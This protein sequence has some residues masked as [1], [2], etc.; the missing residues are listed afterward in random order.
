MKRNTLV[1]MLMNI[2]MDI[3]LIASFL[4]ILAASSPKV[5]E[6]LFALGAKSW[7]ICLALGAGGA[8]NQYMGI[9][10][11]LWVVSFPVLLIV[12]YFLARKKKYA[13]FYIIT[14]LDTIIALI[15]L[16][17]CIVTENKY[18][19]SSAILDAAVSVLISLLLLLCLW[20][21]RGR[22]Q[23]DGLREPS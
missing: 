18:T 7:F 8:F 20:V 23:G 10:A 3:Y 17:Q 4:A 11:F 5:A 12:F 16:L 22:G 6:V 15:W 9:L 14:A 1:N 19:L 2:L 21:T 13:P